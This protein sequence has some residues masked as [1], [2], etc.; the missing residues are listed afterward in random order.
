MSAMSELL[1]SRRL[2]ALTRVSTERTETLAAL[3]Y[4]LGQ[5]RESVNDVM[6]E[7]SIRLLYT[8]ISA[9]VQSLYTTSAAEI[10]LAYN[11]ADVLEA[12][13]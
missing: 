1:T 9:R 8:E 10:N 6:V 13:K 7:E 5:L 3:S 12:R 4:T 2:D 11:Y